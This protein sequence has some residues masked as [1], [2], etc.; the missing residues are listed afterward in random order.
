MTK[1]LGP[2]MAG[3][4]ILAAVAVSARADPFY[5]LES[6]ITLKGASPAWDY[7]AFDPT[8][9]Y[10]FIDRRAAGVT[11]FDVAAGQV[12]GQIAQS[13]GANATTLIPEFDRGYT[14]NGDGSTTSFELSSLKTIARTALGKSADAAFYDSKTKQLAFMMGDEKQITLVDAR[15]G[16]VSGRIATQSESLEAAAADGRGGLFVAERDRDAVLKVD[17]VGRRIVAEWKT[18]PC[19]Q[20][21][22]L[23]FDRADRRI[24]VGCRGAKPVLAVL[25]ADTGKLVA[26]LKIGRGNDGVVYDPEGRRVFTS[27]GLDANL[28]IFDQQGPDAYGL[29][30]AVTTRP[31]ARTMAFDPKSKKVYLVTAEGVVDPAK[32]V[33]TEAGPFYPNHYF[34][35]TFTLLTYA[36]V[37]TK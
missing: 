18:A 37:G 26:V 31:I 32:P 11:V 20:P 27:N 10:L 29:S 35:D 21:T 7:L 14:T 1:K 19:R 23:A 12:V 36:P 34:P 24:F 16:L 9:S 3:L 6:A 33:N 2:A 8:R 30:Q 22:G 17:M 4:A 28:V 15:T 13:E 5:R 25:N